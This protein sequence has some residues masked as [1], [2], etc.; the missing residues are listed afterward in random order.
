MDII[1]KAGTFGEHIGKTYKEIDHALDFLPALPRKLSASALM[2]LALPV[3][4]IAFFWFVRVPAPV[5]ELNHIQ[6]KDNFDEETYNFFDPLF[7]NAEQ[8]E[9]DGSFNQ[10]G[11]R[12]GYEG[13]GFYIGGI[14]VDDDDDK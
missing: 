5:P 8:D 1:M 6:K 7:R 11:W 13:I 10:D 2:L 14:R 12:D 3:I 4:G 9:S